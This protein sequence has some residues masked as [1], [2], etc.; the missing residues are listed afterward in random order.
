LSIFRNFIEEGEVSLKSDKHN[1]TLY[2]NQYTFLSYLTQ[3]FLDWKRFTQKLQRN[4]KYTFYVQQTFSFF[5]KIVI[6]M[7]LREKIL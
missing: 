3:F 4:S 5:S 1:G 7:R 2:E 6:F